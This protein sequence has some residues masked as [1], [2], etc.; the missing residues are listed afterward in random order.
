MNHRIRLPRLP[1]AVGVAALASALLASGCSPA[2]KPGVT[3]ETWQYSV[4]IPTDLGIEPLNTDP[5]FVWQNPGLTYSDRT[6]KRAISFSVKPTT[7]CD[8]AYM[9]ALARTLQEGSSVTAE[10]APAEVSFG[11]SPGAIY[12][13]QAGGTEATMAFA[14]SGSMSV[15]AFGFGLKRP[16]V[17]AIMASFRFRNPPGDPAAPPPSVR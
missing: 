15:I 7:R 11:G 10:S 4:A 13:G 8:G 5:K 16:D 1:W 9:L 6:T 12:T 2:A 14:C 17:E 3:Y